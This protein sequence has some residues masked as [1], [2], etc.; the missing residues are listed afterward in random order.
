M[1]IR[2]CILTAIFLSLTYS[3]TINAQQ[4]DAVLFMNKNASLTYTEYT[5]KGKKK[6]STKH[7]TIV[8]TGSETDVSAQIKATLF[9]ERDKETFTTNYN[10]HCKDGLFSVDMLRFFD[11]GKL[12]EQNKKNLSVTIDGDVLEFPHDMKPGDILNDGTISVKVNNEDNTFTLVT[13]TFDVFN[14]KI[15]EEESITTPAGTFLCQKVTFD[16]ASKFGIISIKGSGT[17]WYYQNTV[18][19]RSESYTKK[20][21]LIGYHQLTRIQQ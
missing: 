13:L 6:G 5:K 16:F 9:D 19:I 17:E 2:Y 18:L 1:K 21:K 14:R 7:E 15:I 8:V 4:C 3:S 10:A 20:G 11:L 12:S